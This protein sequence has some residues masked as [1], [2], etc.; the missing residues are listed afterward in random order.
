MSASPVRNWGG[1]R[2][3]DWWWAIAVV[4]LIVG[5][6]ILL[7]GHVPLPTPGEVWSGRAF[8]VAAFCVLASPF[9][10]LVFPPRHPPGWALHMPGVRLWQIAWGV[11]AL[12][13]LNAPP[14]VGPTRMVLGCLALWAVGVA[15]RTYLTRIRRYLGRWEMRRLLRGPFG[16]VLRVVSV[17]C[18]APIVGER[19]CED[20]RI[21]AR[22]AFGYVPPRGEVLL[23]SKGAP[24]GTT[25]T[26]EMRRVRL[27][28]PHQW[29]ST[30]TADWPPSLPQ[31]HG[32]VADDGDRGLG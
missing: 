4:V 28:P 31:G 27:R 6:R 2:L 3:S 1:G 7:I 22:A 29:K 10:G 5:M 30:R 13:W 14:G 18:T 9:W 21:P 15:I 24:R 12:L 25:G 26:R 8:A 17:C 23:G 20:D 19:L 16:R 11:L 32:G